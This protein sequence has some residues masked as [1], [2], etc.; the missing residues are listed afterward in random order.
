[1]DFCGLIERSIM[2]QQYIEENYDLLITEREPIVYL[3]HAKIELVINFASSLKRNNFRKIKEIIHVLK[4]I[5][6]EV[7]DEKVNDILN[8]CSRI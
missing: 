6:D 3:E 7:T 8:E 4:W 1:M 2:V 5:N